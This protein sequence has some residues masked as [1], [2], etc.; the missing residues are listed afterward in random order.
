MTEYPIRTTKTIINK[1]RFNKPTIKKST[2]FFLGL[3]LSFLLLVS[4]ATVPKTV[5]E[6]ATVEELT[7]LGQDSLDQSN[8][9]AAEF[10]YQTILNRFGSD[11]SVAVGAEY[12]IAHIRIKQKKWADAK[13]R[14]DKILSYYDSEAADYLPP[15][16]KILAEIDYKKIP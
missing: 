6:D 2:I 15:H 7:L 5:P 14:L 4:C 12:E 13:E 3:C 16:Y 1:S 11:L 10:Y 8:Y 9:K